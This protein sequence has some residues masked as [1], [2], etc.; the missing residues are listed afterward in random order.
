MEWG[1]SSSSGVEVSE[2]GVSW[3]G[4]LGGQTGDRKRRPGQR[5][6]CDIWKKDSR[7][8]S[9]DLLCRCMVVVGRRCGGDSQQRGAMSGA[10]WHSTLSRAP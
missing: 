6:D 2:V 4:R 7:E 1:E 8:G 3:S 5:R 10:G 9:S